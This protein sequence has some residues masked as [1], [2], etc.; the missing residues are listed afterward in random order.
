[1]RRAAFVLEEEEP[2]IWVIRGVDPET[3]KV[4][5]RKGWDSTT[6]IVVV[7]IGAIVFAALWAAHNSPAAPLRVGM[8]T[9]G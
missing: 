3:F 6:W 5:Q 8:G 9:G 2:G 7:L 4:P 1:M